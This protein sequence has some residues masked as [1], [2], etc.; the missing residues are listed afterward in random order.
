MS[1]QHITFVAD[2]SGTPTNIGV[3]YNPPFTGSYGVVDQIL[4][5]CCNSF[6]LNRMAQSELS[7]IETHSALLFPNPNAGQGFSLKGE[8]IAYISL[9]DLQGRLLFQRSALAHAVE[10]YVSLPM[11][12]NQGIYLVKVNFTDSSYQ[13]FKYIVQP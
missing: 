8:N 12:L 13:T 5:N 3:L 2:I 1:F 10:Q 7:N 6:R 4:N 11:Q 9:Y